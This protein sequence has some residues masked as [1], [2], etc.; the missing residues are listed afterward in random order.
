MPIHQWTR[1]NGPDRNETALISRL[2]FMGFIFKDADNKPVDPKAVRQRTMLLALPFAIVGILAL[3]FLLH[4]EIGSGFRMKKQMAV[5]LLSAAAVSFGL[6]A[7]IFGISAKKQ[8]MEVA[9]TK[10]D[11]DQPWLKRTDWTSGR[12]VSSAR[13]AGWL[14]W[15]FVAFWCI[16]SAAISL[17]VVPGQLHL[18][19]RAALI[20]LVFPV[21]GLGMIVFAFNTT[22][23]WRKFGRSVFEMAAVPAA[24][25]GALQGRIQVKTRLQ[26]EH[27][28]HLR[29]SCVRRMTTGASNNR[30]TSEKI[31]W[32]DEKWLRA[33][34]P[35]T[36][37][38]ETGIPVFFKL[39]NNLP[40]SEVS[41]G[42]GIHWKLEASAKLRGP[43]YHAAFDV[44]VFRLP[45]PPAIPEDPTAQFQ[46]SL[47]E[48][49]RQIHS[50]IQVNDLPDG[51]R[52]FIFPAARNPGFASGA[53]VV[54]LIWTG[55]VALL[56]WNRAPLPFVLVFSAIDL[57]MLA[58]VFDL[59]FRRSRV[60]VNPK[61][62]TFERAW[63]A[64][65]KEQRLP[66]GEIKSIATDVG[67]TAGHAAY[68]DL[69]IHARSGKEFLLAKNLNSK[70]EADWLVRQMMAAMKPSAEM[71]GKKTDGAAAGKPAG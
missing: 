33:D 18:G 63:F 55:I 14:L 65:K 37:L 39:P 61:G 27:G 52:E 66:A 4:D 22:R 1:G 19:N 68:H 28:L 49:R 71:I 30:Q 58:F 42:D 10:A 13:K 38:N 21:I 7:L 12:I 5:G 17:V 43:D 60:A 26:P 31:L 47:D 35:Q 8:A 69:K 46:M 64:Y 67:A 24:S 40:E 41:R 2:N 59:W 44:P 3:V 34:L 15:T 45:E 6:I 70:P 53:S 57:L 20:A 29:L 48:I 11:D 25:G 23:A 51:G 16:A 54:C 32:Q 62:V 36:G 50:H 9:A 56:A